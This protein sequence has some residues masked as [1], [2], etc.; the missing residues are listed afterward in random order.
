VLAKVCARVDCSTVLFK[1]KPAITQLFGFATPGGTLAII[2]SNFGTTP[3]TVAVS[4]R[5]FT[6]GTLTRNLTVIEWKNTVIGVDWPADIA[7]VRR[8]DGT[9]QVT[10][11]GF[12]SDPRSVAFFPAQ[13]FKELPSGDVKVLSCGNDGNIDCCNG[14]VDPADDAPYCPILTHTLEGLHANVWATVGNDIDTDVFQ[15]ALK[16]DWV[17]HSFSWSV[18][19][20]PG[21]G[22]AGQPTGFQQGP[23]WSPAVKWTVTPNDILIYEGIITIVG[24][25]GVPHK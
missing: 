16:N 1:R 25:V 20:E 3:G 5:T 7:G 24:P 21:Q 23:N 15:V 18:D 6:G 10:A 13:D 9:L 11:N 2:G 14:K 4:L 19:V 12:T 17:M 22:A 8:Q